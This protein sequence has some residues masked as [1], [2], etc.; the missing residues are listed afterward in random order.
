MSARMSRQSFL[1]ERSDEILGRWLVGIVG[2]G[3]GGSHITQQLSHLGVCNFVL[4]D[5]DR[6]EESNLNRLVGAT[7]RDVVCE[8]P[9]TAV[10]R[11]L[12]KRINR[13]AKIT[14][15]AKPWQE[16]DLRLRECDVVF[17]C[18]DS[19]GGREQLERVCRRFLIPYIDVGMDVSESGGGYVLSGQMILSM[20]GELCMRCLGFLSEDVLA[21]EA[22]HYGTAGSRPQ[23]IWPNGIL[24]SAAVG[25]FVQMAT[26]WHARP[27]AIYL[28]YDGNSQTLLPSNRLNYTAGKQCIHFPGGGNLGEAFFGDRKT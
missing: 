3:G 27:P 8:A 17:G 15:V 14:C 9:K 26:P 1:G 25:V 12:V 23:V 20:P 18:V 4:F 13:L 16:D 24:A 22:E 19:Y 11:R 10:A 7:G 28:E 2:L 5:P 6:I 21:R